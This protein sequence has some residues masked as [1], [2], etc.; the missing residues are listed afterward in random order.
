M[1]E[2]RWLAEVMAS[3]KMRSPSSQSGSATGAGSSSA[4]IKKQTQS[5]PKS[6]RNAPPEM[7][8]AIRRKQN[9]EVSISSTKLLSVCTELRCSDSDLQLIYFLP[10]SAKR[11]RDRKKAEERAMKEELHK[12]EQALLQLEQRVQAL[13]TTM[14]RRK[15][16]NKQAAERRARAKAV[17]SSSSS[18]SF[19]DLF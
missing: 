17:A 10:Q 12:Q 9:S 16:R 3:A 5:L 6:V 14:E 8:A 4:P 18:A 19:G 11:S 1:A 15:K 13:N 7:R 2:Q